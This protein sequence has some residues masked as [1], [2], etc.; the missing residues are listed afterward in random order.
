MASTR[1]PARTT[2]CGEAGRQRRRGY[3]AAGW[4]P[5][6]CETTMRQPF[7]T[8]LTQRTQTDRYGT[9]LT[10]AGGHVRVTP[11]FFHRSYS[12]SNRHFPICSGPAAS[13]RISPW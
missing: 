5:Y 11:N 1:A 4:R 3:R 2:S 7:C 8:G 6:G 10:H 9:G 12:P 13:G